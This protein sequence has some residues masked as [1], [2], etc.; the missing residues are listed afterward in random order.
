MELASNPTKGASAGHPAWPSD[1]NPPAPRLELY[2]QLVRAEVEKEGLEA[3]VRSEVMADVS[4]LVK[5]AT[6][7]ARDEAA[8]AKSE[9]VAARE[10]AAALEREVAEARAAAGAMEKAAARLTAE[11]GGAG[12]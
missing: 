8:R 3:E 9:A 10:A 11:V 6:S 4:T 12:S 5:D 1:P 2:P 7:K